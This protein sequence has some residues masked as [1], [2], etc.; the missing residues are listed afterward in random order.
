MNE[1]ESNEASNEEDPTEP[2]SVEPEAASAEASEPSGGDADALAAQVAKLKDQLLRTAADFDNFRK[3][4]RRDVE[5]ASRRSKEQTLLQLLPL[6]DNLE[7]AVDAAGSAVDVD[8][9]TS[10]VRMVLRSFTDVALR[11]DLHRVEATGV[12][13]DPN[14][15]DAIQQVETDEHPPGTCVAEITPGYKLGDRLLRPAQVV[16]ARPPSS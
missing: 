5:D 4:S 1:P 7:R 12:P 9:V 14:V 15:H 10:G 8:A 2:E 11:L 3:R 13:F 6:I 16:V